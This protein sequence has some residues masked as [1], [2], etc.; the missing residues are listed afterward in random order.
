MEINA[1]I[2]K[3]VNWLLTGGLQIVITLILAF[4]ALKAGKILSRRFILAVI[5]QKGDPEF[6][7]R[8]QTLGSIVRYILSVGIL[9]VT[10][11]IVLGEFGVE[12]GPILAAAGVVGLA[13]GFGAQNSVRD[14]IRVF[15]FSWK[16]KSV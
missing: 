4:F 6:I 16:T 7:K 3:F 15:L 10:G 1:Y 14:V 9:V 13:V 5:K 12:I 8:T 2:Q 11:I